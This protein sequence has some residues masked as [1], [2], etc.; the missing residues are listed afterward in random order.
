VGHAVTRQPAAASAGSPSG[1]RV[2]FTVIDEAV[3]GLDSPTDPWSIQLELW[4]SG[5]LEEAR[6]RAAV[7]QALD[8]HPMA[9]ARLVPPR[10][11]DRHHTWEVTPQPDLDPLRV[12]ECRD[13]DALAAARAELYALS[14]PLA[15]SPPL[16]IRLA[17][18]PG[19]EAVMVN[20]NHAAF[21]GF[22]SLRV[23]HSLGRAYDG[24]PE[25]P[26]SV[27]LGTARD[28]RAHLGTPDRSARAR[29]AR[30]LADKLRDLALP[31]ARLAPEGASD[32]PGYGLHH[33][34]LSSERTR[35][36]AGHDGP[37][38]LNDVL[39]AAL[40]L[41]IAGWNED[42]GVAS[43]RI[44]VL[45]PVNL[46]PREWQQDV[47]TNFVLESRVSTAASDRGSPEATLAAVVAET[48]R[49]KKGGG[50]AL[51]EALEAS[52]PLPAWAKRQLSPLLSLTGN[53]LVDTAVLSNLGELDDPPSFGADAGETSQ[54]W[55]SAPA[56]MPCGLSLGV[57]TVAGRLHL[58]FRYRWALWDADAAATF[59]RRYVSEVGRGIGERW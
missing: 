23:L 51:I 43:G 40:T 46:R 52:A 9:R 39:V 49:I 55:F 42:H 54:A 47:A 56:R 37:G 31:P 13:D 14:V 59:A 22:G 11:D 27:D 21:D 53:R 32:R 18:H 29:R 12:I 8:H 33:V 3:H 16:R 2:P 26:P 41:A 7:R 17:R 19:G 6:L 24:R 57:V 1:T 44:S 38:T 25:P 5:R 10:P 28:L 15:E 36:L 20:V 34:A 45:V 50:A 30:R 58:A 48:D 4:V 35:A